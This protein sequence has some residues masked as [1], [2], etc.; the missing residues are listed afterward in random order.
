M[1]SIA[2]IEDA[3]ARLNTSDRDALESPLLAR[4][5]GLDALNEDERAELFASL[6]DA[7]QE[8]DSGSSHS[9]DE[10]RRAVRGSTGR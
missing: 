7:E 2:E 6:D 10:L 3:I 1:S 4:R 9:A 5:F 8:I